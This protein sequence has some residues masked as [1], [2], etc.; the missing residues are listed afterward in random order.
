M[1]RK[2]K[3]LSYRS[4][5]VEKIGG[6]IPGVHCESDSTGTVVGFCHLVPAI[7]FLPP[8]GMKMLK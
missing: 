7:H 4:L 6:K 8:R 1:G 2:K 3:N 5:A